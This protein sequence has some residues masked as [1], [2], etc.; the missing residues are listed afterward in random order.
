MITTKKTAVIGLGNPLMADEGIG[1]FLIEPLAANIVHNEVDFIDAGVGGFSLLHLIADRRKVILIDCALMDTP[2]G[3][4]KRF[5]MDQVA[6]VKRLL[7]YSLHE[8]D[9][10]SIL[11][12]AKQLDQCPNEIVIFGIEPAAITFGQNLSESLA[13]NIDVYLAAITDELSHSPPAS[14]S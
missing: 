3:T 7:H 6:S 12:L 14:S 13:K 9:L 5:T 8:A 1:G 2:P 11:E 4:I 10:F